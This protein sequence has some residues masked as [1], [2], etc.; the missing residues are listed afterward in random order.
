ME[1]Q[2]SDTNLDQHNS[3][4]W[5]HQFTQKSNKTWNEQKYKN[6]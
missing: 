6:V 1:G 4:F 2:M 3:N 5:L